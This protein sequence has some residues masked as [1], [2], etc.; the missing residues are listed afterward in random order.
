[1]ESVPGHNKN[2]TFI[3]QIKI[4]FQARKGS[5]NIRLKGMDK[6]L[7]AELLAGQMEDAGH[8]EE[9]A[10]ESNRKYS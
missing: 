10:E 5:K 8:G 7:Q 9:P 6:F 3:K 2:N 1:M 4:M